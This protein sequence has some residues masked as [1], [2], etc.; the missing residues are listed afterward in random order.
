LA[1]IKKRPDEK[2]IWL[3]RERIKEAK[4]HD[5][6]FAWLKRSRKKRPTRREK[7]RLWVPRSCPP[8]K[9]T[10]KPKKGNAAYPR[11]GT[12]TRCGRNLHQKGQRYP[13]WLQ[14]TTLI[15]APLRN[16]AKNGQRLMLT[17]PKTISTPHSTQ[18]IFVKPLFSPQKCTSQ[19]NPI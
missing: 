7:G 13:P 3:Y 8:N 5:S 15:M 18:I 4:L 10:G 6:I 2:S 11:A 1:W 17:R 16:L 14:K 19:K 12:P 9:P